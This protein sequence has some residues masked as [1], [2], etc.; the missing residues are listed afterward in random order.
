MVPRIYFVK[1]WIIHNKIGHF[2]CGETP[3]NIEE[4]REKGK[5]RAVDERWDDVWDMNSG[6]LDR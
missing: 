6:K 5:R 3:I 2:L 4:S 1:M